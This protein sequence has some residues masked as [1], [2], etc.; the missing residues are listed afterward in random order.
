[1]NSIQRIS[2]NNSKRHCS[3]CYSVRHNIKKCDDIRLELLDSS[4]SY[5]KEYFKYRFNDV[6]IEK[7]YFEKWLF[8]QNI[9]TIKA[10]SIRYC[11]SKINET[12]ARHIEKIINKIYPNNSD[13][14]MTTI[15]ENTDLNN[16]SNVE[17]DSETLNN[18][19]RNYIMS[20]GLESIEDANEIVRIVND[21]NIVNDLI[22]NINPSL[23]R[24]R[25]IDL[26]YK[27][28]NLTRKESINKDECCI[29]YDSV[30]VLNMIKYNCQHSFCVMC[31]KKTLNSS[32]RDNK[33]IV[34]A[35]CREKVS[36]LNLYKVNRNKN[37]QTKEMLE[38]F[39]LLN[40]NEKI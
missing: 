36:F 2:S 15:S 8:E 22:R 26:E 19:I 40:S 24:D 10:Y 20:I 23:A 13:L 17:P 29:C 38:K 5:K 33:D 14:N 4:I 31:V 39:L 37:C 7:E 34:C 1:M 32:Q 35:L 21:L 30:N 18:E 25:K 11:D 6:N 3:F 27:I 28:N 9:N 12:I 16:N